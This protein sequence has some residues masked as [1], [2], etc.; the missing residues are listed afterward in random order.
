MDIY[1]RLGHLSQ[2]FELLKY[3]L[4]GAL[5]IDLRTMN[6]MLD[7]PGELRGNVRVDRCR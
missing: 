1:L 3:G 6:P 2:H 7:A 4:W 5:E